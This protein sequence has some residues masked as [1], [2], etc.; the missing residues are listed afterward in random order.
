MPA[1]TAVLSGSDTCDSI[2]TKQMGLRTDPR[3]SKA[4]TA[5][6]YSEVIFCRDM[7][8]PVGCEK[9]SAPPLSP[10]FKLGQIELR[11]STLGLL[12]GAVQAVYKGK[13]GS[14]EI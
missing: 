9:Q 4:G 2:T 6:I 12:A 8:A 7:A 3:Q 11:L 10:N 13:K 14:Q 5:S 1:N